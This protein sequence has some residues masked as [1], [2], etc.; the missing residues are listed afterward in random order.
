M[1]LPHETSQACLCWVSELLYLTEILLYLPPNMYSIALAMVSSSV[2][3]HSPVLQGFAVVCHVREDCAFIRKLEGGALKWITGMWNQNKGHGVGLG[4]YSRRF[5]PWGEVSSQQSLGIATDV[6][7]FPL[8]GQHFPQEQVKFEL[9]LS[10]AKYF[11]LKNLRQ[12][13]QPYGRNTD[14]HSLENIVALDS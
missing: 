5:P 11:V 1:L 10:F 2:S 6:A 4:L 12:G 8:T 13:R 3:F 9:S 7:S 14:V